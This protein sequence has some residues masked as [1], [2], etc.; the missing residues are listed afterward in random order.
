MTEVLAVRMENRTG[1]L[2]RVLERLAEEHINMEYA[3]V[4]TATSQGK[5]LGSSTPPTQAGPPG[6]G[7]GGRE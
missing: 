5:T 1:A 7:R 4:S 2:A 6:A 3:Y